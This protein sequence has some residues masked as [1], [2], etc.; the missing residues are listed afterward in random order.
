MLLAQPIW[1]LSL[2]ALQQNILAYLAIVG[3]LYAFDYYRKYREHEL[4]ASQLEMR[5]T[6][7]RLQQLYGAEHRFEIGNR[8][9]GALP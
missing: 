2:V 8:R 6:Q 7:A 5:L 4:K 1:D 9:E 3:I